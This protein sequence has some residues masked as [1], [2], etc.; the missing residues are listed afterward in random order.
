MPGSFYKNHRFYTDVLLSGFDRLNLTIRFRW[1]M[2]LRKAFYK[3]VST[4]RQA[5]DKLSST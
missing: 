5:Q 3:A 4:L 1:C 2:L